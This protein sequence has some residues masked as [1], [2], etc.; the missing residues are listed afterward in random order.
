MGTS[1]FNSYFCGCIIV[2]TTKYHL[3]FS[4]LVS[5]QKIQDTFNMPIEKCLLLIVVTLANAFYIVCLPYMTCTL[6]WTNS[7]TSNQSELTDLISSCITV[8]SCQ[9]VLSLFVKGNHHSLKK[10]KS[11]P[12]H[13]KGEPNIR[14]VCVFITSMILCIKLLS[15]GI[16]QY[17]NLRHLVWAVVH[18]K[19][20]ESLGT[21]IW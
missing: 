10:P 13:R 20:N 11:K 21:L 6:T 5:L 4:K 16:A 14:T 7:S 19:T 18:Q 1:N 15:C 17:A 12:T 2:L 9:K 8:L 3:W